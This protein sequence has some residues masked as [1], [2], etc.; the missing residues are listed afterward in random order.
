MSAPGSAVPPTYRPA[1]AGAVIERFFGK[2]PFCEFWD[3]VEDVTREA[4]TRRRGPRMNPAAGAVFR[5]SRN[6]AKTDRSS[7]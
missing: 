4:N 1:K 2:C 3:H 6:G 5:Q 7:S